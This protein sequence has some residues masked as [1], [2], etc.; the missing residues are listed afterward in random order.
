M[1]KKPSLRSHAVERLEARFDVDKF[2]LLH[3]LENGRFDLIQYF[4]TPR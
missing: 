2:W 3:E 1:T 4:W